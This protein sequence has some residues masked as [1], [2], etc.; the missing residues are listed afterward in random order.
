M[1]EE[2]KP[3]QVPEGVIEKESQVVAI[4]QDYRHLI[5]SDDIDGNCITAERLM[6]WAEDPKRELICIFCGSQ[7]FTHNG[8]TYCRR[9]HEYKG[10]MPN[11][12][13]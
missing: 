11:C 2:F 1:T 3:Q 5:G 12:P 4:Y 10:I 13:L 7:P 9:C 6:K 8:F